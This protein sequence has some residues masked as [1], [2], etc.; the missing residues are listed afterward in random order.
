MKHI[1]MQLRTAKSTSDVWLRR[2]SIIHR[3]A[4]SGRI[5]AKQNKTLNA[6]ENQK[7]QKS[8]IKNKKT[9][10]KGKTLQAQPQKPVNPR[11]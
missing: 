1:E 2:V 10:D 4:K 8:K 5:G 9:R 11:H 3:V 6:H 7:N